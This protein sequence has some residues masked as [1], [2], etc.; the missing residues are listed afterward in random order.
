MNTFFSKLSFLVM[1][2]GISGILGAAT[3]PPI[4]AAVTL[5]AKNHVVFDMP[6][7]DKYVAKT[8]IKIRAMTAKLAKSEPFYVVLM[9]PGGE[10]ESGIEFIDNLNA[11]DREISTVTLFAASMGFQAAQGLGKRYINV[12]GTLMSHKAQGGFEGEFPG[13]LDSRY[14]YYL[15]RLEKMD[16]HVV[17]RSNGKL[18]IERYRAMY[19]NELWCEGQD[20]VDLGLADEAGKIACDASLNGKKIQTI[21]VNFMGMSAKIK[22]TKAACP[23]IT[24]VLDFKVEAEEGQPLEYLNL[25]QI[26]QK[27]QVSAQKA[28]EFK[29]IVEN[30]IETIK[31]TSEGKLKK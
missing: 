19:E 31:A 3:S 14:Q 30:K 16:Q 29:T 1:I 24:A 17:D 6:F 9:S 28:S 11:M 20:C 27:Y 4:P 22:V 5:T 8:L 25:D 2:L 7:D 12:T 13:Q 10:I 23:T 15:R 26:M 21:E 18:T